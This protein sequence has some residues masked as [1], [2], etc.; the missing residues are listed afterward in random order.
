MIIDEADR[1]EAL[2]YGA[3]HHIASCVGCSQ[4]A[5]ER[6]K[7]KA[8]LESA[9]RVSAP[10][11]FD[12]KLKARLAEVKERKSSWWFTPAG[13]LRLGAATAAVVMAVV[14]AQTSGFFSADIP[15]E[16]FVSDSAKIQPSTQPGIAVAPPPASR[17]TRRDDR[18]VTNPETTGAVKFISKNS[19][20]QT[21]PAPEPVR[22]FV[23]EDGTMVLMRG[24]AGE[25]E[26]PV[27]TVSVGAQSLMYVNSGRQTARNVST[28][29]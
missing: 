3:S 18:V 14:A 5:D 22:G 28:S 10:P 12:F 17:D 1:P 26:V 7:L 24:P 19:R 11:D 13:Y 27:P 25:L 21:R 15:A 8:L 6:A 9:G 23:A 16:P 2:D 29:F 20:R 4:F